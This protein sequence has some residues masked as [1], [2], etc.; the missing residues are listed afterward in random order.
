MDSA[1]RIAGLAWPKVATIRLRDC[2]FMNNPGAKL[3]ATHMLLPAWWVR[4]FEASLLGEQSGQS[5]VDQALRARLSPALSTLEMGALAAVLSAMQE[6]VLNGSFRTL[7]L[8]LSRYVKEAGAGA[9]ARNKRFTYEKVAQ[10]LTSI[11]VLESVPHGVAGHPIFTADHW[12]FMGSQGK[13]LTINLEPSSIG[14]E[15]LLGLSDAHADLLRSLRHVKEASAVLGFEAPLMLWKSL[16]LELITS[17]PLLYLRL[18]RAMQ[19]EFKWLQLDGT[20]GLSLSELFRGL[21]FDLK[22]KLKLL[23]RLGKR[24]EGHGFM[25]PVKSDQY[26]AFSA[27]EQAEPTLVWQI[28][29]E[30]LGSETLSTFRYLAQKSLIEHHFSGSPELFIRTFLPK[31]S[32][33]EDLNFAR[34]I[35]DQLLSATYGASRP[36]DFIDWA[37][38]LGHQPSQL[39]SPL[40]LFF[41]LC[42]R[43]LSEEKSGTAAAFAIPEMLVHSPIGSLFNSENAAPLGERLHAFVG[44]ITESPELIQAFQSVPLGTFTSKISR[45]DRSLIRLLEERTKVS[46][47]HDSLSKPVLIVSREPDEIRK[48]SAAVK[49]ENSASSPAPSTRVTGQSPVAASSVETPSAG[50]SSGGATGSSSS[51]MLKIASDE[52]QKI[53]KNH[54]DRYTALKKAYLDSLDEGGRKL[55]FDV[56]KRMQAHLFEE[57]LR[58]RLLRFMV[59]HPGA[60]R[61]AE[62]SYAKNT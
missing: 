55:I 32:P 36:V 60:W 57:H 25:A 33:I 3:I 4:A 18:E 53:K 2:L 49:R 7:K 1:V 51:R 47:N 34:G 44:L 43:S 61:S 58:Q 13:D 45:N 22:Q 62:G 28:G 50:S 40:L 6:Q 10:I 52:L 24:F 54:P 12:S 19:W 42:L 8:D 41:E 39:L 20:F 29:R 27:E 30:R 35:W 9:G 37:I 31:E 15:L 5:A 17:E 59:E 46:L 21:D 38:D 23:A 14:L 48:I 56:Q 16:W 11:K 26:L